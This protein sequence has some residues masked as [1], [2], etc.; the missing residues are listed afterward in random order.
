MTQ[1]TGA[2]SK[3]R[4]AILGAGPAGMTTA[5]EL[6]CGPD[7]DRYDITLYQLGWQA[8]GLCATGRIPPTYRV[9][10]N[11]THFLFGL[12]NAAFDVLKGVYDE[13]ERLKI[14]GYGT[15]AEQLVPRYNLMLLQFFQGNWTVWPIRYPTNGAVPGDKTQEPN[16]LDMFTQLVQLLV[17]AVCGWRTL[18][19]LQK[20]GVFP[21]PHLNPTFCQRIAHAVRQTVANTINDVIKCALAELIALLRFIGAGPPSQRLLD[22][23]ARQLAVLRGAVWCLVRPFVDNH[24][25]LLRAW[26]LFDLAMTVGIGYLRDDVLTKGWD[27]IDAYDLREWLLRHGATEQARNSPPIAMWYD[28]IV[29]FTDGDKSRPNTSAGLALKSIKNIVLRTKGTYAYQLAWQ[30]GDSFIAPFYGALRAR[31]VK[32]KFFQKVR[33]VMPGADGKTI[34][35]VQIERQVQVRAGDDAYEPFDILNG[36]NVW[37]DRPRYEQLVDPIIEPRHRYRE[38]YSPPTGPTY[39]LLAG[40]DFDMVVF[41]MPSSMI[42]F[43][44]PLLM[45]QQPDKWGAMATQIRRVQTQSVAIYWRKDLRQLGWKYGPSVT[46]SFTPE[47]STWEDATPDLLQ[48]KWP[49][50]D[51]PKNHATVLGPLPAPPEFPDPSDTQYPVIMQAAADAAGDYWLNNSAAY[52]WPGAVNPEAPPSVDRSLIVQWE[53]IASYGPLQ[54]YLQVAAGTLQYRPWPS[55]SGYTNLVLAGDWTRNGT[56]VGSVEG[57]IQSG[58]LAGQAVRKIASGQASN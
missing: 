48:E 32:F 22:C 25:E 51:Q 52:L 49:A 34:A 11:G 24:L 31:G 23:I 38:F 41:A 26:I 1:S 53:V 56:D 6:L 39:E 13:L 28:A 30:I 2:N 27:S 46:S 12:Y 36:R 10:Q 4:V 42:R 45:A 20:L 55:E 15:F 44:A 50:D 35:S 29:N 21:T 16:V 58:R 18:A 43:V 3:V 37:P 19:A 7:A 8:G 57:A 9:E 14:A 54:A 40:R 47:F 17:E 33:N 5:W